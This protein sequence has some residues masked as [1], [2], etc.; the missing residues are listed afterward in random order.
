[1]DAD[2]QSLWR[3][4]RLVGTALTV[5]TAP[6]A[7]GA[8]AKAVEVAQ[9]GDVMVVAR[10]G[11]LRHAFVGD[12]AVR[13]YI[14]KGIAGLVT[15]GTVTD[16]EGIEEL[17]FPVFCRGVS[18]LL[19]KRGG[20]EIG[21]VN[22]PVEIG[23]VLVSPG[24]MILADENGVLVATPEEAQRLLV[25]CQEMGEWERWAVEQMAKGKTLADVRAARQT[26]KSG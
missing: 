16:R 25:I 15:D 19:V 5:Q 11:E 14:E 22:V 3:S 7:S 12:I 4:G 10:G 2:I 9:P 20:P 17:K 6:L 21:A 18:A 23:G 8:L 24:D 1:M 26:Y 13:A